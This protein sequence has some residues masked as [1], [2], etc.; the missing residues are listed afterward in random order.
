MIAATANMSI[1]ELGGGFGGQAIALAAMKM[2]GFTNYVDIDMAESCLL[3]TQHIQLTR[4]L[5]ATS[6]L[7]R[8]VLGRFL[9][10]T[11][12][13][14]NPQTACDMFIS[15]YALSELSAAVQKQIIQD[16]V[17]SCKR[18]HIQAN[19]ISTHHGLAGSSTAELV[20]ALQDNGLQLVLRSEFME[21][22]KL[23]VTIIEW[24]CTEPG[25]NDDF[26]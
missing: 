11:S 6:F 5:P 26:E 25:C 7:E 15:N 22:K 10:I 8:D 18:G 24:G 9:C 20:K 19:D 13:M 12:K 17:A 4:A 2:G 14:W 1:V 21:Q 3:A 16:V 23:P